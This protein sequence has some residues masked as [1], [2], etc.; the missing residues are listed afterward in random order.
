MSLYPR[1][2]PPSAASL[3]RR[4]PES[5]FRRFRKLQIANWLFIALTMLLLALWTVSIRWSVTFS[6][7]DISLRLHEGCLECEVF[8]NP[9]VSLPGWRIARSQMPVLWS[10]RAADRYGDLPLWPFIGLAALAWGFTSWLD[11][12]NV[13]RARVGHCVAC[14]YALTGLAAQST[15]P[16]CGVVRD[17]R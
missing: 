3:G 12:R 14:G 13:V 7:G 4:Y 5:M 6:D 9:G 1:P 16:E 11:A 15:C 2:H 10:F 17:K 8:E